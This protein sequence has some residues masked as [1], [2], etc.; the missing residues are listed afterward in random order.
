MSDTCGDSTV[1][2]RLTINVYGDRFVVQKDDYDLMA[3]P[4]KFRHWD[5]D[6]VP[7]MLAFVAR[8]FGVENE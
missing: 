3:Y 7:D 2:R 5:F 4:G 1:E 8:S 6:N